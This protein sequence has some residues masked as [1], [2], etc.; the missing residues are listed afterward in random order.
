ML[1]SQ[2]RAAGTGHPVSV[3]LTAMKGTRARGRLSQNKTQQC[4][5]KYGELWLLGETSSHFKLFSFLVW[6][7]SDLLSISPSP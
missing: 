2:C 3:D 5:D 7:G 4:L 1:L 6:T